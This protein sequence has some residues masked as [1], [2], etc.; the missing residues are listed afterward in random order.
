[1]DNIMKCQIKDYQ[2]IKNAFLEFIPGLNVII[3]PSNNGKS[4]IL[5]AIKALIYT[6]PGTTPIR[7]GQSSYVVGINYN[8]HTVILQKGL[9]ESLYIVDGEKYTKYGVNTPEIVS[10]SLN[11]KELTLN[12]NKEQ[13]NFWDQMKYPFLIDRTSTELFKFIIDS[14]DSDQVSK[15]LKDMVSDRQQL[16]KNIDIL[17][18]SI[19]TIDLDIENYKNQ[20]E[21]SKDILNAC[22]NIINLQ[23]KISKLNKL[24]EI[25]ENH[26]NNLENLSEIEKSIL[27]INNNLN[28]D[29][30]LVNSVTHRLNKLMQLNKLY[31]SL[32]TLIGDESDTNE[33]LSKLAW[34]DNINKLDLSLIV[35]KLNK[36]KQIKENINKINNAKK[37]ILDK[38]NLKSINLNLDNKLISKLINL[39]NIKQALYNIDNKR[40]DN[41]T[42]LIIV[43]K[44]NDYYNSFYNY[45]DI[46]PYCG[47]KIKREV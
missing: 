34:V 22:D 46:C 17:Q 2:I 35:T 32:H 4:S 25:K 14:S 27:N 10:K 31:L 13:L 29:I 16:S 15:A 23:S 36:L 42:S 6:V 47:N 30:S 21:N 41:E 9:K 3:G 18:G 44:S 28:I 43:N 1:M 33:K 37:D 5:K 12:G 26:Y 7:N 11:I 45:F 8:N 40:V 20:L 38:L 19:N 24:K 39:K